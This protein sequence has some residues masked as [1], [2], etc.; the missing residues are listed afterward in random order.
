M[1]KGF[2]G[3]KFANNGSSDIYCGC[4]DVVSPKGADV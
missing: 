1:K 3:K 4:A 2:R